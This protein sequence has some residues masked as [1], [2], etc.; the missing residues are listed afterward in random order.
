MN[1]YEIL[2]L[3]AAVVTISGF[4]WSIKKDLGAKFDVLNIRID[5]LDTDIRQQ[6]AKTD[7]RIDKLYSMFV[8]LVV[9]LNK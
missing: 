7:A 6:G 9:K 3:L 2:G 4:M 8:D 5:K 1:I